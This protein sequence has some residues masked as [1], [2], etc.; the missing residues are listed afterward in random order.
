MTNLEPARHSLTVGIN[1]LPVSLALLLHRQLRHDN[2]RQLNEYCIV[3]YCITIV[4]LF[5][6]NLNTVRLTNCN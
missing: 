3:L 5:I 6:H 1:T 2:Y 4:N